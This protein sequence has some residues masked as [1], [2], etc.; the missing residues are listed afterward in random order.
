MNGLKETTLK[1]I[2]Q[3]GAVTI[4]L[5]ILYVLYTVMS[6][7][8]SHVEAV[9]EKNNTALMQNAVN[10]EKLSQSV[11]KLG[12]IIERKIIR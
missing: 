12:A 10:G 1:I 3:G 11:D 6:N 8:F 2:L 4:A 5:A 9:I 7:D